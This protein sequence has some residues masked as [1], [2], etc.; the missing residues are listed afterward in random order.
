MRTPVHLS[1]TN[2]HLCY[3]QPIAEGYG[4]ELCAGLMKSGSM[5]QVKV[6]HIHTLT[7]SIII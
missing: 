5:Y 1:L 4:R 6:I 7:E 2:G 3:Q